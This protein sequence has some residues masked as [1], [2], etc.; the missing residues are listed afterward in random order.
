M[1]KLVV[2]LDLKTIKCAT[3]YFV[4][5]RNWSVYL[6]VSLYII[7]SF[8]VH[9]LYFFY[10]FYYRHQNSITIPIYGEI[11]DCNGLK[12]GSVFFFIEWQNFWLFQAQ[13][14]IPT[15]PLCNLFFIAA[16]ITKSTRNRY[17]MCLE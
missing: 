1:V 14:F 7:Y 17:N 12:Y 16:D 6:T 5:R 2:Q 10:S 4:Q 15:S 13:P 9:F 11:F 8:S 3:F